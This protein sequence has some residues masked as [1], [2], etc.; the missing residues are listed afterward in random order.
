MAECGTLVRSRIGDIA[1]IA[2]RSLR[3]VL[4]TR[5][6]VIRYVACK[7]VAERGNLFIGRIIAI[8]ARF[9][10]LPSGFGTGCILTEM[11]YRFVTECFYQYRAAFG[12][13]LRC[14]TRCGRSRRM[15]R[16]GDLAVS[17]IVAARASVISIPTGLGTRCWLSIMVFE[18]MAKRGA[19][20]CPRSRCAT[21]TTFSRLRA[22]LSTGRIIV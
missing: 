5:R 13:S 19:F 9:V 10:W 21:S 20:I 1:A 4:G 2:L 6:V 22:I 14:R 18:I 17:R 11:R 3:S 15:T 16:S 7:A 8:L 12:T